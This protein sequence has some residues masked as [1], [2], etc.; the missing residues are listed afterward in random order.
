MNLN[1]QR[2]M[3]ADILGVGENKVWMDPEGMEEISNAITRQDVRE[4]IEDEVIDK[5]PVKGVSRGKAKKRQE[6]KSKGR[7]SG[8]GSRKGSKGARKK[9]KDKWKENIRSI[10]SYLR[11]LR[12]S[13]EITTSKYRDLYNMASG[14]RFSSKRELKNYLESR[15]I[16]GE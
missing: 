12:D 3:A 8:H 10:R 13:D 1:S 14:G 9:R 7:Q 4:L 11:E 16:I 6:Q 2:R 5:R 15:D